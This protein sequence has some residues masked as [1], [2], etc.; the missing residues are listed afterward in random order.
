MVHTCVCVCVRVSVC[1]HV[2]VCV[3]VCV[4]VYACACVCACV[5]ADPHATSVCDPYV[6]EPAGA[7]VQ[8]SVPKLRRHKP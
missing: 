3:C 5:C 1:V 2:C 8:W 6:C 4:H 7:L